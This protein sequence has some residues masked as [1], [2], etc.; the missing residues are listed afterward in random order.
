MMARKVQKRNTAVPMDRSRLTSPW[1]STRAFGGRE[2]LAYRDVPFGLHTSLG[3]T[4]PAQRISERHHQYSPPRSS[5]GTI[6]S[7]TCTSRDSPRAEHLH[8]PK[9]Y[10]LYL[11]PLTASSLHHALS[12]LLC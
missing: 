1:P 2:T 7:T 5:R 3:P 12:D 8:S 4:L 9:H 6:D 11:D 10:A